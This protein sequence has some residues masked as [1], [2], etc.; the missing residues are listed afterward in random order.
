MR[1]S[2]PLIL[3][4]ILFATPAQ[5]GPILYTFTAVVDGVSAEVGQRIPIGTQITGG[6]IFYD[7]AKLLSYSETPSFPDGS[8]VPPGLPPTRTTSWDAS[9]FILWATVAGTTVFAE[10]SVLEIRDAPRFSTGEDFW[11]LQG[12]LGPTVNVA[13]IAINTI[14]IIF[15]MQYG[16]AMSGPVVPLESAGLRDTN[17]DLQVPIIGEWEGNY[18]NRR[19]L[20][21]FTDENGRGATGIGANMTSITRVPEP[22]TGLLAVLGLVAARMWKRARR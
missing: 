15:L 21:G 2:L 22:A 7:D 16:Q 20:F 17:A 8:G 5:A 19:L 6:L 12:A 3:A 14:D 4:G 10:P 18:G 9:D 13:G 11:K 1:W